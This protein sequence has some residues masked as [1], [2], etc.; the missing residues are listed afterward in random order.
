MIFKKKFVKNFRKGFQ[1]CAQLPLSKVSSWFT[2][3]KKSGI[4]DERGRRRGRARE[5]EREIKRGRERERGR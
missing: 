1:E 3:N 5:R 4:Y 2:V